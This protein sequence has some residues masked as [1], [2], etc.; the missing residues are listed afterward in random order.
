MLC[1]CDIPRKLPAGFYDPD[2]LRLMLFEID[3][4]NTGISME[5]VPFMTTLS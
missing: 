1:P 5:D 2:T 3:R 4:P